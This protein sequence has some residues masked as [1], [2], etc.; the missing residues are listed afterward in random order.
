MNSITEMMKEIKNTVEERD[1]LKSV[2][3][4]YVEHANRLIKIAGE[5]KSIAKE[6][7]PYLTIKSGTTNGFKPKVA[8]AELFEI[9]KGGTQVD[10]NFIKSSYPEL[11]DGQVGNILSQL[12]LMAGVKKRKEGIKVWLYM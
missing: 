4:G 7:D 11:N 9:I 10:R 6:I 2:V 3:S 1:K 8:I 5:I 12:Q